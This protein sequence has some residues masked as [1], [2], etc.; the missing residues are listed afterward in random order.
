MTNTTFANATFTVANTLPT[1]CSDVNIVPWQSALWALLALALNA[2]TQPSDADPSPD[3]AISLL[4]SSPVTCLTDSLSILVWLTV[5]R[6]YGESSSNSLASKRIAIRPDPLP[7]RPRVFSPITTAV[8]FILGPLPQAVKLAG[9][10]GVPFTQAIG[11]IFLVSYLLGAYEDHAVGRARRRH[12]KNSTLPF[13][14]KAQRIPETVRIRLAW[15]TG[16]SEFLFYYIHAYLWVAI[17]YMVVGSGIRGEKKQ[18]TIGETI[19]VMSYQYSIIVVALPTAVYVKKNLGEWLSERFSRSVGPQR[20]R[21]VLRAGF[22]YVPAI[23]CGFSAFGLSVYLIQL[24]WNSNDPEPGQEHRLGWRAYVNTKEAL[25][26]VSTLLLVV[27]IFIICAFLFLFVIAMVKSMVDN[28]MMPELEIKEAA[29]E[30][31]TEDDKETEYKIT[32]KLWF[33]LTNLF[34]AV[35]YYAYVYD[36]KGTSKPGWSEMLG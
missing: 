27:L 16:N 1:A 6:F 36:L 24:V 20:M 17:S 7:D 9:M 29:Q 5:G 22:L 32:T 4:R 2:M 28:L 26:K 33:S 3:S 15:L 25:A 31:E 18:M 19:G 10:S 12:T 30:N 35:L 34:F 23:L 13:A 8:F 11:F 21:P 14:A